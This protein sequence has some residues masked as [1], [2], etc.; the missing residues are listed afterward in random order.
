MTPTLSQVK[1]WDIKHLTEAANHWTKT[2]T[3]WEDRFT[4]L[5]TQI[6]NPGGAPWEGEAAEAAQQRA[7][8][9]RLIVVGLA[10]QLHDASKIARIG[11]LQLAEAQRLV[12]RSVESAQNDGFTVGEDFSVTD[13]H[14][15][16][17][18]A[19]AL[20]QAKA[21]GYAEDLRA[22]VADLVTTDVRVSAEIT[23]AT[24]GLG[25]EHFAE[26]A[27]APV[28]D[29]NAVTD[30]LLGNVAE[31]K[32]LTDSLLGNAAGGPDQQPLSDS[33]L[34]NVAGGGS[35]ANDAAQAAVYQIGKAALGE[36]KDWFIGLPAGYAGKLIDGS[37]ELARPGVK[38][39]PA[40]VQKAVGEVKLGKLSLGTP[41]GL[42]VSGLAS[43]VSFLIDQN[44]PGMT[45]AHAAVR[46]GAALVVGTL[47]SAPFDASVVGIPA[48]LV[49]GSGAGNL[50]AAGVDVVW[51]PLVAAQEAFSEAGGPGAAMKVARWGR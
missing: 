47:A 24:A 43:G 37:A 19:A 39:A 14:V 25:K 22:A 6:L 29:Q 34:A 10:D 48:G 13:H 41:G 40:L 38:G 2:A 50:T 45:T 17:R 4:Q 31:Q 16:N 35:T 5:A 44:K 32:A 51:E 33:L 42:G 49:V 20:R 11:A 28:G 7:H 15:Y 9:D 8:S 23:A 21:E 12:L 18:A 3:S 36:Q 30:A 46:N 1:N 26:S 27:A